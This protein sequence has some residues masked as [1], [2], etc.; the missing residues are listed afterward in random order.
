MA[1][2]AL[3]VSLTACSGAGSGSPASSSRTAT[4]PGAASSLAA[5]KAAD[6]RV[7]LDLLLGEQ[8]LIVAKESAAAVNHSDQYV[9][10]TVL[11]TTNTDE[12]TALL[13]SAFGNTAASELAQTWGVQNAYLVDYAIGLVTHN[14][15]KASGA[16]SGLQTGFVPQFAQQVTDLAQLPQDPVAQ[17]LTEQVLELKLLIDAQAAQTFGAIY[18][19]L[20]TAYAQSQRLGDALAGRIAQKFSDKFPGDPLAAPVEV[21]VSL[22]LLLQESSYLSTMTTEAVVAGRASEVAAATAALAANADSL[23]TA[24]ARLKGN[25]AATRFDQVWAARDAALL[26]YAAAGDAASKQS[27]TQSTASELAALGGIPQAL[28]ADQAN[29]IVT[30]IDDQRARSVTAVAGD[31]RAAATAMQPIADALAER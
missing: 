20:H 13:S 30:A 7:H 26:G 10:Y 31:D 29:A 16:I 15:A 18:P 22:A 25:A 8:V 12:L 9:P 27:L 4:T 6:L 2:A 19:A 24:F 3:V 11:L 17:L 1:L 21:R 14:A 28:L 23:G 5:T